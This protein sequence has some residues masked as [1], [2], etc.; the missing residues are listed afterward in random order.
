MKDLDI[1]NIESKPTVV[2]VSNQSEFDQLMQ[3][4]EREGCVWK[5]IGNKPTEHQPKGGEVDFPYCIV[6]R[7]IEIGWCE[8]VYPI[9]NA[10]QVSFP[11]YAAKHIKPNPP[12]RDRIRIER[13]KYDELVAER[14]RYRSLNNEHFIQLQQVLAEVERLR[15]ENEKAN[16]ESHLYYERSQTFIQEWGDEKQYAKALKQ[17]L[18]SKAAEHAHLNTLARKLRYQRDNALFFAVGL[19]LITA[20]FA[21]AVLIGRLVPVY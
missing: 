5:T 19:G 9:E 10:I 20:G 17:D 6:I 4:L 3:H 15:G 2:L 13:K 7:E 1:S 16:M 14:D 11:E 12:K 8:V 18:E 21:V